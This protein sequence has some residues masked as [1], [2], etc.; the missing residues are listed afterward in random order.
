LQQ[1]V[2]T[3]NQKKFMIKKL[4]IQNFAIIDEL[5]IIFSNKLTI[6]TGETGAGKSILLG[7]LG[8]I[9]GNRADG[10]SLY[11]PK[12]KCVIEGYFD[13]SRYNIKDFFVENELDYDDEVVVRREITPAGKSRAFINDTP[14]T[15]KELQQ[16]SSSLI[17]LHQQFDT[18]DIHQVSFQ[19]R[20]I[21]ALADNDK[22]LSTYQVKFKQLQADK[23][24]LADFIAQSSNASKE[25]DFLTFQLEEFNKAELIEG[26]QEKLENDLVQST[27]AENI[28]R[29]TAMAYR[30]IQEDENSLNSQLED[31]SKQV[32][33]MKKFHNDVSKLHTRLEELRY[34]MQDIASEFENIAESTEFDG[35][36]IIDT[37]IR[38]D[39]IYKLQKKHNVKEINELLAIQNDLQERL[40]GFSDL[41]GTIEALETGIAVQEKVLRELAEDLSTRRKGVTESFTEKVHHL[42]GQ[43]SMEHARLQVAIKPLENLTNVGLDEVEF[44]FAPNKGSRFMS[45]KD[46][47]SGGELSRL[48]LCTKSLV[49]SAI[50]LPTLIFDEIDTGISG[51]VAL[52]MGRILKELANHHQVVSITHSP[53]IASKAEKHYFVYKKVLEDRTVTN[54]RELNFDERVRSIATM[55]STNPPTAGALENARELLEV[56]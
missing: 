4:L 27:N 47:A 18:L 21:D 37:Q 32:A 29:I 28:K 45:I 52:K 35:Q 15:L 12:E 33:T 9:M 23:R 3:G 48:T 44:L 2:F 43:L 1:I 36:K 13:V 5:E 7:G 51:D 20:M 24:K 6:I 46:A 16:L 17:D 19:L 38:L 8:L 26:E 41:S 10:V 31:L 49:A 56:V 11:N 25:I 39:L 50:P 54:V 53:Q 42:L 14:V 40:N 30:H 55:L 22:R 34:E